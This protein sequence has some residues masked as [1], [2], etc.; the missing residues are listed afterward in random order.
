MIYD[1]EVRKSLKKVF[2]FRTTFIRTISALFYSE[3]QQMSSLTLSLQNSD[4]F[5]LKNFSR[6]FSLFLNFGLLNQIC[7]T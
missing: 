2:F 3:V 4:D 6:E 1:F 7:P 5:S